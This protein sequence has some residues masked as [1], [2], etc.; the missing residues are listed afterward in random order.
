MLTTPEPLQTPPRVGR[1]LAALFVAT[2]VLG[3]AEMLV[4]GLLDRIAEDVRITI[5]A[6]GGLVTAYALGVAAGGPVLTALTIRWDRRRVLLS[7]LAVATV[8]MVLPVLV[9]AMSYAMFIGLRVVAGAM[10]GLVIAAAFEM[11]TSIVE[12]ERKGRA[13]SAVFGGFAVSSALGVPLGTL[14]GHALGWRGAFAAVAALSVAAVVALAVL[15]PSLPGSTSGAGDLARH[16]FSPRVLAVLALHVLVFA[17]L[18]SAVTY[19]VPFLESVTGISGPLVSVFLLLYGGADAVGALIGGRFADR[20]AARTLL[21]TT[22]GISGVLL[23]LHFAGPVPA[24]V[25]LVLMVLGATA[26]AMVPSLQY[27]VVE[28][29]GPGGALAQSLPASAANL[30]VAAGALAGGIAINAVSVSAAVIMGAAIGVGAVA[31]AW[32]TGRLAAPATEPVAS[33]AA[34][35]VPCG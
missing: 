12:P 25:A 10:A 26:A 24:L 28:L 14:I 33:A 35:P 2:F 3:S 31:V 29:A 19:I 11:G 6:A 1:V 16:A 32:A 30:G 5:P 21:V 27:R 23:M 9:P 8:A 13:I 20:D 18:Y 15:A 34:R 4:V 7:A 22:A 17:A